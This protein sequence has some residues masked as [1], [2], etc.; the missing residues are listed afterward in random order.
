MSVLGPICT[1]PQGPAETANVVRGWR[2]KV[3]MEEGRARSRSP[4]RRSAGIK[5]MLKSWAK[6][7]TTAVGAWRLTHAIVTEDGSDCG[8]GLGRLAGL[9]SVT[10]SS[11]K[12]C[13]KALLALLADTAL[14]KL[15]RPVPHEPREKTITHHLRATDLI[16]LIHSHNRRKFGLIFGADKAALKW[17]WECLFSTEVG[18]NSKTSIPR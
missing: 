2:K 1:P 15:V 14:P 17:F 18:H 13:S 6:G 11:E 9:A 4:R 16:R 3:G 7:E 12:N 5:A 10:S 8:Y